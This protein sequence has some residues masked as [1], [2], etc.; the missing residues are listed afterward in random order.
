MK[1][2]IKFR[3]YDLETKQMRYFDLDHY[4]KNEHDC[5]G[6]IMQFTGVQDKKGNGIYEGDILEQ[7]FMP[8]REVEWRGTAFI[9]DDGTSGIH[10]LD[11][12]EPKDIKVIGNI[13]DTPELLII[14]LSEEEKKENK[15]AD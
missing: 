12:Y 11:E 5:Y 4:D 9:I 1:R 8:P 13:Y 3:D 6:N 14:P 2:E 10:N 7:W 15:K